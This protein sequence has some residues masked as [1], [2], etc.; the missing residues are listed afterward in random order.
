MKIQIPE[1]W[2]IGDLC[3]FYGFKNLI[4]GLSHEV[5]GEG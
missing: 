3:P 1:I 2:I 4:V 5:L